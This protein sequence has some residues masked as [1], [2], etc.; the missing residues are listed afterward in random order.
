MY[1]C[2]CVCVCVCVYVCVCFHHSSY[3]YFTLLVLSKLFEI[4]PTHQISLRCSS[5][6]FV[7]GSDE[8]ALLC[9]KNFLFLCVLMI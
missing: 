4:T 9:A 2:V 1:K 6:V 8:R 3:S 5:R 7:E